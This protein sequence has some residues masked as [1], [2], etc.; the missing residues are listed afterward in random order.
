MKKFFITA[1]ALVALALPPAGM[2]SS[3]P[4][5]DWLVNG[6]SPAG[7]DFLAGD[8]SGLGA[9][10]FTGGLMGEYNS[11]ITHNGSAIKEQAHSEI[12]RAAQV[13]AVHLLEGIGSLAR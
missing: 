7:Q 10:Q 4:D 11:R 13:Q 5:G 12:G 6:S 9:G 2:A 3:T 1:G 8:L